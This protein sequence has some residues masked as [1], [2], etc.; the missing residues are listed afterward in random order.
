MPQARAPRHTTA[1]CSGSQSRGSRERRQPTSTHFDFFCASSA[2]V[3]TSPTTGHQSR[4]P[5][6]ESGEDGRGS[7]GTKPLAC[8]SPGA[9]AH[10][11]SVAATSCVLFES[12]KP[13]LAAGR[14]SD[15]QTG[16][17]SRGAA[18]ARQRSPTSRPARNLAA[19][20]PSGRR[21]RPWHGGQAA[22]TAARSAVRAS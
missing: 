18:T 17:A 15:K 4:W 14:A 7:C 11:H 19:Q 16:L 3:S 10:C 22:A 21:R 5:T 1:G 2:V 9:L 6:E 20:H 12:L 8:G 13:A